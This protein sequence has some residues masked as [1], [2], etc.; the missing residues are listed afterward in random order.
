MIVKDFFLPVL[1]C[2]N[3]KVLTCN[4]AFTALVGLPSEEL[5]VQK[6]SRLLLIDGIKTNLEYTDFLQKIAESENGHFAN[7]RLTDSNMYEI[8]TQFHCQKLPNGY[9]KFYFKVIEN[10][11]L[12]SITGLPNGW[13]MSSRA[14]HLYN[15]NDSSMLK[16]RL[17]VLS[18]DN[19]STINFRYGFDI[20]DDYLVLLGKRLQSIAEGDGLVVRFSNARFGILFENKD[21]LSSIDSIQYIEALC[22]KIFN[23]SDN[24]FAIN[25]NVAVNK[26]FSI[27]ISDEYSSYYSYFEMEIAAETAMRDSELH[28]NSH[29]C[30]ANSDNHQVVTPA[31]T[32]EKLIIDELPTAIKESAINIF[33]Q[34][35]YDVSSNELIGFEALSRWTHE[36]LGYIAPDLFIRIAEDIGFH[37]EYD[38]WVFSTVCEQIVLWQKNNLSVPRVAINISFKTLEMVDLVACLESIINTTCC[39]A[40]LLEVEVTE[41]ASSNNI[42][43]LIDNVRAIKALGINVAIDDFGTGYTSLSLIKTISNSLST[44]KIDRS[45]IIGICDTKLDREF[46]RNIIALGSVLNVKILAEGVENEAQYLLLQELGCDYVQGYFFDKALTNENAVKLIIANNKQ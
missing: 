41:T 46:V 23:L 11:A 24:S 28:S 21:D 8:K 25:D 37:F 43:S 32:I 18:V 36:K 17:I 1:I 26:S 7:G 29:Y 19:F 2:D 34:P 9:Y 14:T 40:F 30:F 15:I 4:E 42:I 38:L 22:K 12:D 10:K 39:P 13:A 35:Q 6:L 45:L 5:I 20:G 31:L 27:G 33:Y 16:I 44:L 3:S